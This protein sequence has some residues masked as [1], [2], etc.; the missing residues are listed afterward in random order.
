MDFIGFN[1]KN[2]VS[3]ISKSNISNIVSNLTKKP[4]NNITTTIQPYLTYI[5][6]SFAKG[7]VSEY[8][9]ENIY[10]LNEVKETEKLNNALYQRK[11]KN[12]TPIHIICLKPETQAEN[13][14]TYTIKQSTNTFLSI[15]LLEGA[16]LAQIIF[17]PTIVKFYMQDLVNRAIRRR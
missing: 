16:K 4:I 9:L 5:N 2:Q 17:L 6:T 11:L 8:A 3:K 12:L 14:D 15:A 13:T 10:V 7:S 1:G